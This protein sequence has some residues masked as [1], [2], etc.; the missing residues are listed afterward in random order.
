MTAFCGTM[1]CNSGFSWP[2]LLYLTNFNTGGVN[3]NISFNFARSKFRISMIKTTQMSQTEPELSFFLPAA[4]LMVW[5]AALLSVFLPGV[6]VPIL[7]AV[8]IVL[9]LA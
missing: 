3:Q 6:I 9:A 4:I 1:R 5:L 8:P 2:E 7:L